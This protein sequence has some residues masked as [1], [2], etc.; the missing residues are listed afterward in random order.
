MKT[1]PYEFFD[2]SLQQ[3]SKRTYLTFYFF[4]TYLHFY[5]L[6]VNKWTLKLSWP[7]NQWL[8]RA[9]NDERKYG[10]HG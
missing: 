10:T 3:V 2:L 1:S 5:Q 7:N 4:K 9:D 6:Y 8:I